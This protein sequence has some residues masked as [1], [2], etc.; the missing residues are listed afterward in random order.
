MIYLVLRLQVTFQFTAW[1]HQTKTCIKPQ[2][3]CFRNLAWAHLTILSNFIL[4]LSIIS[5][6]LKVKLPIHKCNFYPFLHFPIHWA[7]I[8]EH[9]FIRQGLLRQ[10]QLCS[11]PLTP[12]SILQPSAAFQRTNNSSLIVCF[13]I[14]SFQ[15]L[16]LLGRKENLL[17]GNLLHPAVCIQFTK[18]STNNEYSI[19]LW[20]PLPK[21]RICKRGK[22]TIR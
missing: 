8:S 12:S 22:G 1:I 4:Y 17:N 20:L 6:P 14:S 18:S 21:W 7:A 2:L 9:I 15:F 10:N 3:H 13:A 11:G 5:F 19:W 16:Y